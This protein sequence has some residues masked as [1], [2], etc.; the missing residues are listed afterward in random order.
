MS[1]PNHLVFV[2]PLTETVISRAAAISSRSS[3]AADITARPRIRVVQV[4]SHPMPSASSHDP[5]DDCRSPLAAPVAAPVTA[6]AP[7]PFVAQAASPFSV[8]V[9][10]ATTSLASRTP[11]ST[12]ALRS[13]ATAAATASARPAAPS[14]QS[15]ARAAAAASASSAA[16]EDSAGRNVVYWKPMQSRSNNVLYWNDA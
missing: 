6:P 10:H 5:V 2:R 4:M 7:A 3:R 1:R 16:G 13:A 15:A 9:P 11:A 8:D 14:S 12:P